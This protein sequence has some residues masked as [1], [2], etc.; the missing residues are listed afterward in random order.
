MHF[1]HL[2]YRKIPTRVIL[3]RNGRKNKD[4]INANR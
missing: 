3:H 2:H 4:E 1:L